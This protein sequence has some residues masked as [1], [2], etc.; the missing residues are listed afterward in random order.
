MNGEIKPEMIKRVLLTIIFAASALSTPFF[1]K[2]ATG[3]FRIGKLVFDR[4]YD[5]S[6][7]VA[8]VLD[9]RFFKGTFTYLAHGAQ[10]F[11][12][13]SEGRDWTL[14]LFRYDRWIHPWRKFIR[15]EILKKK[16][17]LPYDQKINRLFSSAKL[18]FENA[19]DLT[20]LVYLHLNPSEEKLP[21]V[22][23]I[24][25]L[26]R[27]HKLDLSGVYFAI[28]HRARPLAQVFVEAIQEEDLEKFK[29]LTRSFVD[30]LSAR[31]SRGIRNTDTKVH[32]NFGFWKER[33]MEWDF[34]N[35][36]IDPAMMT[37]EEKARE[38]NRFLLKPKRYMIDFPQWAEEYE[39]EAMR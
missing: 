12:F 11:V 23:L 27:E 35:Y 38:I 7:A 9:E 29:R 18:A 10:S 26:G 33:A 3:E 19:A 37:E 13:E 32:R 34:G 16:E 20:G 31:A 14:K 24:D 25:S 5:P 21:T 2:K 1:W 15:N 28:Q 39:R 8:A 17:R 4:P 6:L 22:L 30:L 36:R